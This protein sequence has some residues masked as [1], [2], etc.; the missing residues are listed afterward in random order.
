[1]IDVRS[2]ASSLS[3]SGQSCTSTPQMGTPPKLINNYIAHV[4]KKF[5]PSP[6]APPAV[7]SR[8]RVTRLSSIPVSL[9][10][11]FMF[12]VLIMSL[13]QW[14]V[15]IITSSDYMHRNFSMLCKSQIC[16]MTRNIQNSYDIVAQIVM[17][18]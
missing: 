13:V 1:M 7:S 8:E 3:R 16:N 2:Y 9:I 4:Q 15:G 10:K 6:R 17:M 11:Y 5:L 12:L 14:P 18:Y